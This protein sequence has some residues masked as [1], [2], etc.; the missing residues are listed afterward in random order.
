[1]HSSGVDPTP[2]R[3]H[4]QTLCEYISLI[5]LPM[6]SAS[7]DP[8]P[9]HI[10]LVENHPDTLKY[11]TLFLEGLGHSVTYA[12]T[13]EEA[14]AKVPGAGADVLISDIGLS[15]GSGWELLRVLREDKLPHPFYCIALS[16]YG[17][18]RDRSTSRE[19]GFRHHLLKPIDPE[20][21]ECMLEEA[22]REVAE[23]ANP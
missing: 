3:L 17:L 20:A 6:N 1:M 9:L 14:L 7:T 21:L 22:A 10:F 5:L 12:T 4:L 11:M 15:D 18:T 13:K 23:R 16:G 2:P 8:Q 19:A